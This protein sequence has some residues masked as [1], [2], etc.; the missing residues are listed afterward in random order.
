VHV[1]D[2]AAGQVILQAAGGSIRDLSGKMVEMS[3]YLEGEKID[4]VLVA[5]AKGQHKEII[6][7]LEA[8]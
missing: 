1:W 8:R 3:S 4:R 6:S 7:T 2:V 5:A